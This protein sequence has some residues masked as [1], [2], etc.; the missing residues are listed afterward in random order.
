MQTETKLGVFASNWLSHSFPI[1]RL[2]TCFLRNVKERDY[3]NS[4]K[5][6]RDVC[7][8]R[9]DHMPVLR[10]FLVTKHFALGTISSLHAMWLL[11]VQVIGSWNTLSNHLLRRDFTVQGSF[12]IFSCIITRFPLGG[13]GN[14]LRTCRQKRAMNQVFAVFTFTD[15]V[16]QFMVLHRIR[17]VWYY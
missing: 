16:D 5:Q 12:P 1:V 7:Y 15:N 14:F 9:T 3:L 13:N 6:L 17:K 4:K 10:N 2:L 11:L 8:T